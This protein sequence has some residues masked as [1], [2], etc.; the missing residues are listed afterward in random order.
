MYINDFKGTLT[1][2][3]NTCGRLKDEGVISWV[4]TCSYVDNNI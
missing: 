3:Q 2:L 4:Y 1:S